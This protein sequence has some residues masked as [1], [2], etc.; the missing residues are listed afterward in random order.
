[1]ALIREKEDGI[2]KLQAT[3]AAQAAALEQLTLRLASLQVRICC[4]NIYFFVSL[5]T[6]I[7][8]HKR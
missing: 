1:M 4:I 5:L 3:V 8:H 6:Y 7:S 2:S